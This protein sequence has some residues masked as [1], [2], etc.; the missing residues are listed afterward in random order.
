[1]DSSKHCLRVLYIHLTDV[2]FCPLDIGV[3]PIIVFK[4]QHI[5]IT[6]GKQHNQCRTPRSA[7][8]D[9]LCNEAAN[10]SHID[11]PQ[12]LIY[13]VQQDISDARVRVL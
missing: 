6:T 8:D 10:I 1:M 13:T 9:S 5:L 12:L 3:P 4:S 11:G 2:G 7:T